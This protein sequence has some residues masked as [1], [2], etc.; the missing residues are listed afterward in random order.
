MWCDMVLNV[1]VL[2]NILSDNSKYHELSIMYKVSVI[3]KK[4]SEIYTFFTLLVTFFS[5]KFAENSLK[6]LL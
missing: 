1:S 6:F 3:N 2:L 5:L 4:A